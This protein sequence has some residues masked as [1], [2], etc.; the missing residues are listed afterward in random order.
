MFT[1]RAQRLQAVI[2]TLSIGIWTTA[3]VAAASSIR[4]K[5]VRIVVGGPAGEPLDIATRIVAG[6]LA[7]NERW[8][9]IVENKPGAMSTIG[10]TEVLRQAADGHTILA[11]GLPAAVASALMPNVGFNSKRSSCRPPD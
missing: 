3:S 6:K 7:E 9:V 10:A 11:A 5:L 1:T 2:A 4:G 8:S